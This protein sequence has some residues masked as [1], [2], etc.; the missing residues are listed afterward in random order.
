MQSNGVEFMH[1]TQLASQSSHLLFKLFLYVP[2]GQV[3][4]HLY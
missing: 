3:V 2:L 1:S 4:M